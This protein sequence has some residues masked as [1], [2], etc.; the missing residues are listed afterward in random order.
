VFD[1][2]AS[3][4]GL[5]EDTAEALSEYFGIQL[6]STRKYNI[7][8]RSELRDLINEQQAESYRA[9]YDESCRIELGKAL[10]AQKTLSPKLLRAGE[11]CVL[12][13]VLYDLTGEIAERASSVRTDCTPEALLDGVD[14]VIVELVQTHVD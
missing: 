9:C 6:A 5:D 4:A 14:A 13:A 1:L 10:A 11:Q 2:D 8:P 7:V 3:K 12:G